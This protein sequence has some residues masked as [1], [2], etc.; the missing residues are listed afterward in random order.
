MKKRTLLSLTLAAA[1]TLAWSAAGAQ[2]RPL[3]VGVT[4]GPHAQ[5]FEQVKKVAERDGLKIQIVEF[6]DYVQPNAALSA[7]DLDAN[8]YRTS[9]T[10]TS[11]SRTAATS[12]RRWVTPSTS[13]SA[14]IRRRSRT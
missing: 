7:G 1:V 13:R 14:S 5:I 4:A 2:D 12:S 9:P 6:S 10:S 8:S 11:R 3:K